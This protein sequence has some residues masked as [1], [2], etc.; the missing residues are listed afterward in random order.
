M[1]PSARLSLPRGREPYKTRR[2][3]II[4]TRDIVEITSRNGAGNRKETE[5]YRSRH[6]FL[7]QPWIYY[8]KEP[9]KIVQCPS[10]KP[11]LPAHEK[12]PSP[13]YS[14]KSRMKIVDRGW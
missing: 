12:S 7:F 3:R 9:Q 13:W 2:T 6:F 1:I 14:V 11:T 10:Q 5:F 8:Q 4:H